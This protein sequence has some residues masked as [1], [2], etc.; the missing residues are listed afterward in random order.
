MTRV[1]PP[2]WYGR[3]APARL[4]WPLSRVFG[5]V[6]ALRR[7]FL[8]QPGRATRLPVPVLVVGNIAVGGSGKT[9]VVAWLVGQ[10]SAA[11]Y[12][13]GIVSRG[14]GGRTSRARLL[15]E[16]DDP[17]DV[18]DEP[19]LLAR[20]T[21]VPVAVGVDRPRAARLLVDEAACDVVVSDD[22]LQ[23]YPLAR[24]VEIAVVD[25]Q[26]LGNRWLL[27]AGPLRE[28]LSRLSGVD[29]VVA[30]GELDPALARACADV[31]VFDMQLVG[32]TLH[33]IE[34]EPSRTRAL[35]ELSGATVHAVAGIGRPERFFT[36]LRAA[37]LN[38]VPHPFPDHHPFVPEDLAFGDRAPCVMT[39]KDAV[40][41]RGFAPP[42][43]WELPV[44]A[45]ISAGAF[46]RILEKLRHGR[47]AA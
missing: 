42:D 14:Y 28:P 41:C 2:F 40:K 7:R 30:H 35:L 11:G 27:P 22:G 24:D 19:L 6:V 21:G 9:P 25:A 37:G 34:G 39:S 13:P 43:S 46:E 3:R 15:A 16:T 47:Q 33:S 4:L 32:D 29:V 26:T 20:R 44:S 36:Q 23:H 17:G 8:S 5:L 45:N 18:G 38:V 10:L 1:A 12:R 31:P